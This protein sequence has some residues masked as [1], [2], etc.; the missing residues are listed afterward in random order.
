MTAQL[1]AALR[2]TRVSVESIM[3]ALAVRGAASLSIAPFLFTNCVVKS[4]SPPARGQGAAI[5]H[6]L[7]ERQ[8]VLVR[9]GADAELAA[10]PAA[11]DAGLLHLAIE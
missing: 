10:S 8:P 3:R 6:V 11:D 7:V 1:L 5:D 2:M 9:H 4:L